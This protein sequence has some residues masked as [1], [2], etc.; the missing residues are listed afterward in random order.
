M[1]LLGNLPEVLAQDSVWVR[2]ITVSG[3][4]IT[5]Q[6]IIDRELRFKAGDLLHSNEIEQKRQL[7][8]SNLINTYLFNEV[9]VNTS[10]DSLNQLD[11][12]VS[13]KERWYWI[14]LPHLSL[15]DRNFNE[16]WYERNRDLGRLTY[17]L[18][19]RHANLTGNGDRLSLIAFFGFFPTYQLS[20]S[21]PYIDQRKRIGISVGASYGIRRNMSYRTWDDKLDFIQSGAI[22]RK[23]YTVASTVTFR[24]AYNHFHLFNVGYSYSAISDTVAYIN[25]EYFGGG[26][27]SQR[28]I[29]LIY[30]Y[31][32]DYRDVRQ[33]PL[34]GDF[35]SA[36]VSQYFSLGGKNQTNFFAQYHYF[37][38][39]SKRWFLESGIRGKVSFPKE[40][41]YYF[42]NGLGFGG[43]IARGYELYVVD[44]QYF[45][46]GKN[47]LKYKMFDHVFK[48]DRWVKVKQFSH[49]PLTVFPNIF[50][51]AGYV[52][53]YNPER[54]NS[55]LGNSLLLGGGAGIDFTS[56]Y[57]VNFRINYSLNRMGE[58]K[59]FFYLSRDF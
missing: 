31:R 1:V 10:L 8:R 55:A 46:L 29:S 47:S 7:T 40:Q 43:N 25:P 56:F 15:A 39:L 42:V 6:Q 51:D 35:F 23:M 16:W 14:P 12:T 30:E 58:K 37:L 18:N 9:E 13:L 49:V 4:K 36:S 5:K 17:G 28:L 54:S 53:N 33:Y 19:M 41:S 22:N 27:T 57:N 38:P 34:K 3:Q 26:R 44:G 2:N 11:V 24:P 59:L 45:L 32:R 21:K 50:L 20:Y 48:F 52:R